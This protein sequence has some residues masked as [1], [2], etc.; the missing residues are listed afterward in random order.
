MRIS[1]PHA[2]RDVVDGQSI[3]PAQFL[4]DDFG[5]LGAV[6]SNASDVRRQTPVGPEDVSGLGSNRINTL[7][8]CHT[9]RTR[10]DSRRHAATSVCPVVCPWTVWKTKWQIL[11]T[12]P[13]AG[14]ATMARGLD[15]SVSIMVR[16]EVPFNSDTYILSFLLSTQYIFLPTQSIA[17][18]SAPGKSCHTWRK[19]HHQSVTIL[20]LMKFDQSE[21]E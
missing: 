4:R 9:T 16:R 2:L 5:S 7:N 21:R 14:C 10:S 19:K 13:L 8:S 11:C 3:R 15:M 18:P 12:D 20:Q 17:M 6:H 1:P